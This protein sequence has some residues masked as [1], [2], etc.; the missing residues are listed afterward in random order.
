MVDFM[1]TI[2]CHGL[3]YECHI[4]FHDY[5]RHGKQKITLDLKAFVQVKQGLLR[6]DAVN[7]QFDY[8]VANQLIKN[9]LEG[10]QFNLIETLGQEVA[11][12]L[13]KNFFIQKINIRVTK[14]PLD[15]PN[16][17]S[18]SYECERAKT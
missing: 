17:K 7:V 11:E 8:F 1:D 3:D 2:S 13:L 12:L 9:F 6:D 14:Y 10:K 18:V 16:L 4:G 5:E 15:M